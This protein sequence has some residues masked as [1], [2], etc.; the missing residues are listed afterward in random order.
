M[1]VQFLKR[2]LLSRLME[3]VYPQVSLNINYRNHPQIL[4]LFNKAI[5]GGKLIP[6]RST[7]Q[8]E[9]E[10]TP[11]PLRRYCRLST[12]KRNLMVKPRTNPS[13]AR[14]TTG[15]V[16]FPDAPRGEQISPSDVMI[17]SPYRDQRS[18]VTATFAETERGC[19]H[20]DNLTVDA[21]QGEKAPIVI[22]LLTKPS[23]VS[24]E[25]SFVANKERLNVALSRAQKAIIVVGNAH[26]WSEPVI[27]NI[28]R[29]SNHKFFAGLLAAPVTSSNA[30]PIANPMDVDYISESVGPD[31]ATGT[32]AQ[33]VA[34]T[35]LDSLQGSR[36]RLPPSISQP[37][38]LSPL[39]RQRRA[40]SRTPPVAEAARDKEEMTLLELEDE[41]MMG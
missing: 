23:E 16:P 13:C 8:P 21:G 20:R 35:P 25:V 19:L 6:G 15:F 24:E 9:R 41:D 30:I 40:R 7:T 10:S 27:K 3:A 12:R 38:S 37:R 11:V 29:R 2:S 17:I 22:V 4:E 1:K 28:E 33:S 36:V 5:Y 34:L 32:F 26:L 31:S 18:L 14:S 39:T